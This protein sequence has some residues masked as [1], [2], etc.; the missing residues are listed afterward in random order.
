MIEPSVDVFCRRRR[1]PT[2]EKVNRFKSKKVFST[3]FDE[4]VDQNN[5]KYSGSKKVL[6]IFC[7]QPPGFIECFSA[8]FDEN[9][10]EMNNLSTKINVCVQNE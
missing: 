6:N 8:K 4:Y 3:K 9:V 10:D 7:G 5:N 2:V 1:I